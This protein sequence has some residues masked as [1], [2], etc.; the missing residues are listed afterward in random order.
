MDSS[1]KILIGEIYNEKRMGVRVK[2]R[3]R[4]DIDEGSMLY[5]STDG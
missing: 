3:L 4:R 2:T 5:Q 1:L